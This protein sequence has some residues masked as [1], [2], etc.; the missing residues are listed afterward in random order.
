MTRILITPGDIAGIGP[1]II[2][3]ALAD[4][5]LP[6]DVVFETLPAHCSARPGHPT[7][8]TARCAW[9]ALERAAE[10]LACGAAD[11]VVTGPVA[12]EHLQAIGFPFPGQTEF[13]TER[14][15]V[16]NTAMC[17]SGMHLTVVLVTAHV[18]LA[19]V[20]QLLSSAE[21]IRC[22]R[23]L[24]TFLRQ[25]GI[26]LPRIAICG[27]NPHAGEHGAFGDEE[28]RVIAPAV[29]ALQA[30]NPLAQFSGPHVPDAIFRACL[31]QQYDGVVCMYHDQGLIPLKLIDFDN[32]VNITLG[33]PRPRVSP[34]HGTAFDIAGKNLANPSSMIAAL[35]MAAA[36]TRPR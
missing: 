5:S 35:K 11:G 23:L 26:A 16:N 14:L 6:Q 20:P 15:Q 4:P 3:K 12:K 8:E 2:A 7:A 25:R 21:I 36:L 28:Q 19:D 27:L 1:E 31:A 9:D 29:Q 33:L 18:A 22:A 10:L 34:D 30:S 24:E 32:A 17:L 13:F